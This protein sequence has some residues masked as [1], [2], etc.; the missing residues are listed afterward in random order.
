MVSFNKIRNHLFG[1]WIEIRRDSCSRFMGSDC[2]SLWNVLVWLQRLVQSAR[3]PDI[4]PL[5][6]PCDP[7]IMEPWQASDRQRV[8]AGSDLRFVGAMIMVKGDGAEFAVTF[9]FLT[10]PTTRTLLFS[11]MQV[12]GQTARGARQKASPCSPHFGTQRLSRCTTSLAEHAKATCISKQPTI[13]KCSWDTCT[14][15]GVGS[16][17][18]RS[19]RQEFPLSVSPRTCVESSPTCWSSFKLEESATSCSRWCSHHVAEHPPLTLWLATATACSALTCFPSFSLT[20]STRCISGS[21]RFS[22]TPFCGTSS[23]AMCGARL[24]AWVCKSRMQ[25]RGSRLHALQ[26]LKSQLTLLILQRGGNFDTAQDLVTSLWSAAHS[27]DCNA[28]FWEVSSVV[29]WHT[30]LAINKLVQD[31]TKGWRIWETEARNGSACSASRL[32]RRDPGCSWAGALQLG[33][34]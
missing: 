26:H 7:H 33:T 31:R 27:T 18:D 12:V 24:R 34:T 13:C 30:K 22:C 20:N 8:L 28:Q 23:S 14:P 16:A 29:I 1:R 11:A 10:W 25:N 3:H 17:E 5:A 9:G 4:H 2:L 15:V 32:H 6:G 21:S 19:R